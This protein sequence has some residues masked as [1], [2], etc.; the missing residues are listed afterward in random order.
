MKKF[1]IISSAMLATL[2][3]TNS[4]AQV[5]G[6]DIK[7]YNEV[8]VS[9]G[10]LSNSE[11]MEVIQEVVTVMFGGETKNNSAFGPVSVEYFRRLTPVVAVGAVGSFSTF[12]DDIM[13]HT[14]PSS[15]TID[16]MTISSAEESGMKKV[17]DYTRAYI[18]FMP[19]AKFN[20]LRINHFGM[21]SKVA[22]GITYIHTNLGDVDPTVAKEKDKNVMFNYQASL[23]GIEAGNRLR[24]FAEFGMG[25]QGAILIGIRY[26]F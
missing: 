16:Y 8:S 22:A 3:A 23:I 11:W 14:S 13:Q 24:G 10:T 12:K 18:S 9:Y 17:G 19:A 20:W 26:N 21:Y 5:A 15:S 2:F 6:K 7:T 4:Y 25:E 1:F